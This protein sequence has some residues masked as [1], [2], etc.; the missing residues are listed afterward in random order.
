MTLILLLLT[1]LNSSIPD[2]FVPIRDFGDLDASATPA[3][4]GLLLVAGADSSS[5][6]SMADSIMGSLELLPGEAVTDLFVITPG[7]SGY[8]DISALCSDY[9]EFPAVLT[10]VGHCGYIQ[11]DPRLLSVEISDA[12]ATW[13]DPD[14]RRTGICNFCRRCNP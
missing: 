2:D 6:A 1:A 4:F 5:N 12:W 10:L 11:L 7:S 13:G 9:P 8:A 3:R 14:A